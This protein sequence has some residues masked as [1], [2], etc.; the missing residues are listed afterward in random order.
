[1]FSSGTCRFGNLVGIITR[2][3]KDAQTADALAAEDWWGR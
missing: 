2:Y 1:M 3:D